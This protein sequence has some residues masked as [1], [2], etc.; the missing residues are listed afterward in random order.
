MRNDPD[1]LK[2]GTPKNEH[3]LN[4]EFTIADKEY[5]AKQMLEKSLKNLENEMYGR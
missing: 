1:Y 2:N 4:M 3:L 5:M